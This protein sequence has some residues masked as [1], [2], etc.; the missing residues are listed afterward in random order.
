MF[1]LC[2]L[3]LCERFY[4]RIAAIVLPFLPVLQPHTAGIRHC[5]SM[6]AVRHRF[7]SFAVPWNRKEGQPRPVLIRKE[8]EPT[9]TETTLEAID[10]SALFEFTRHCVE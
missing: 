10:Y 1:R 7:Y 6:S 3:R 8:Q 5:A 4:Q 2:M 9:S